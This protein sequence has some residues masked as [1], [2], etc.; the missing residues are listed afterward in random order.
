MKETLSRTT[1]YQP[2]SDFK[3][4]WTRAE[5]CDDLFIYSPKEKRLPPHEFSFV[6][7]IYLFMVLVNGVQLLSSSFFTAIGKAMK[8]ALLA[9]TRQV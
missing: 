3:Y 1:L 6:K 5:I 9:L 8:G 7:R 4:M 2:V